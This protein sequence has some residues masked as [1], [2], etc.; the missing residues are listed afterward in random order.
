[1]LHHARPILISILALALAG[2]GALD[3]IN[4]AM[5]R[6]D[7]AA[8]DL[9]QSLEN[10][11][12][13]PEVRI[14]KLD[15]PWVSTTPVA[16]AEKPVP[17]A[18]KCPLVY[19]P[20]TPVTLFEI[21]QAITRNCNVRVRV[22]QDAVD[23]VNGRYANVMTAGGAAATTTAAPLPPLI[24]PTQR[25]R[26]EDSPSMV[27]ASTGRPNN[28]TIRWT[29]QPL[30]GFLDT[31]TARF[32]LSW[33]YRNDTIRIFYL[34]T[35]VFRVFA[36]NAKTAMKTTVVAGTKVQ[37]SSSSGGLLGS[38]SAGGSNESSGGSIQTTEISS[39]DS[40]TDDIRNTL[41][42]MHTPGTPPI[43]YAASTGTVMVTDTPDVL[44]QIETYL[45]AENKVL[46]R[47]VLFFVQVLEVEL[48]NTDQLGIDWSAVYNTLSGK[49]GLSLTNNFAVDSGAMSASASV[50]KTATGG[51]AA[52]AGSK[53]II[54]ALSSQGKVVTSNQPILRT[55]N[56][57]TAPLQI[58]TETGYLAQSSSSQTANVGS[59]TSLSPGV[60]VTGFNLNLSPMITHG[61]TMLLDFD[62]NF[63]PDPKITRKESGESAIEVP[64]TNK[65]LF[66]QSITIESGQTMIISGFEQTTERSEKAGVGENYNWL[67]GGGGKTTGRR[68]AVAILVTPII[69]D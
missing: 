55:L 15:E 63:S 56:L 20:A 36:R 28:I 52:F 42:A 26:M 23:A 57:R 59:M 58:S 47:Q 69:Q 53:F 48:T 51:A 33:E 1:M 50:L 62:M 46:T 64:T 13:E 24:P 32:G 45:T 68:M 3:R 44:D 5:D 35:R 9:H 29:G 49:Y 17:A 18:L 27:P 14:K 61:K 10:V 11:R 7:K 2:C 8:A 43:S 40:I 22:T 25:A 67:F 38:N 37:S 66:R 16:V 60:V 12:N 30:A 65:R 4:E 34:E 31:V 6:G 21:S 41:N 39:E 54:N 19:V